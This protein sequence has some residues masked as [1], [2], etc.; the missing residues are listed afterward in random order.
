MKLCQNLTRKKQKN[1]NL[2]NR[3][4]MVRLREAVAGLAELILHVVLGLDNSGYRSHH[5]GGSGVAV[6]V[7]CGVWHVVWG[8]STGMRSVSRVRK[9]VV[10][11]HSAHG[12]KRENSLTHSRGDD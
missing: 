4:G 3:L 1:T 9:P 5:W 11:S 8:K 2:N 6:R 7:G 12:N 10:S